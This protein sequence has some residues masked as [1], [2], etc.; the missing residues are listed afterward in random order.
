MV[1]VV[2]EVVAK[3]VDG[4]HLS[5]LL[6]RRTHKI[7]HLWTALIATTLAVALATG[8]AREITRSFASLVLRRV[9]HT[10]LYRPHVV[11]VVVVAQITKSRRR[12][13][14]SRRS[15]VKTSLRRRRDG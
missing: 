14:S 2:V 6:A 5:Y 12:R 10:T 1:V 9:S 11:V 13:R 3:E 7:R 4:I 15:K 8:A